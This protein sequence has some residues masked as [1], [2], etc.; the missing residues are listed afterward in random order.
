MEISPFLRADELS[1]MQF[2][3]L[4]MYVKFTNSLKT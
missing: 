4:D 1:E 2:D 3:F